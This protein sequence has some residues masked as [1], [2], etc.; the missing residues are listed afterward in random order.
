M[1]TLGMRLL[2]K[3]S[4]R[5]ILFSLPLIAS[6]FFASVFAKIMKAAYSRQREY[7]ADARAVEFSRSKDSLASA[8]KKI[9]GLS[10]GSRIRNPDSAVFSH[11]FLG[12]PERFRFISSHPPLEERIFMLDPS[13][14]GCYYDFEKNP[15]DFL[16]IRPDPLGQLFFADAKLPLEPFFVP[17]TITPP[18]FAETAAQSLPPAKAAA[19]PF[20]PLAAAFFRA[21]PIASASKDPLIAPGK[22]AGE[23]SSP[24]PKARHLERAKK[25]ALEALEKLSRD[26]SPSGRR[27]ERQGGPCA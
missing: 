19:L 25:H 10:T 4:G 17:E 23:K 6:G 12:E 21:F 18:P 13:W 3:K 2:C 11:F 22:E 24:H 15:V 16:E 14:D 8:L 1:Q 9:G 7:L 27:K 5:G 20:E 26:D